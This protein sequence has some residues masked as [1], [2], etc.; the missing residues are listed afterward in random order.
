MRGLAAVF[1]A[2]GS[3]W[4]ATCMNVVRMNVVRM[5]VVRT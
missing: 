2:A 5:N 4:G 3:S 1:L